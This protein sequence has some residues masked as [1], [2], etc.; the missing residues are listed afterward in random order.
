MK[1]WLDYL[2]SVDG[3]PLI[4]DIRRETGV[5][6]N[7]QNN[8]YWACMEIISNSTGHTAEELHSLFKRLFLPPK[9][10]KVLGRELKVPGSTSTLNKSEF[11]EYM[12]KISAEVAQMGI[13]LPEPEKDIAKLK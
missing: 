4:V 3:K 8:Y 12:M 1:V 9:Y 10:I 5:R 2:L 11:V 6:S 7:N 13:T